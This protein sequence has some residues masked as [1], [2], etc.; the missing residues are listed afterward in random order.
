LECAALDEPRRTTA[1]PDFRHRAVGE[2]LA[3]DDLA[4]RVG[5]RGDV[6]D[7]RG[8][9]HH[10]LRGQEQAV[11]QR[12]GQARLAAGLHVARVGLEDLVRAVDERVGQREER[13][14]LRGALR[15]GQRPGR[16][17][18]GAADVGDGHRG[19]GHA[20]KRSCTGARHRCKVPGT[21]A[22]Q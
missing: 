7:L 6:A 1:L 5:Q 4:D 11:E 9:G 16:G 20:P 2:P 12:V 19:R 8:D 15:G 10:A 18:R 17:L 21:C 3:L 14:V 22:A 13:R